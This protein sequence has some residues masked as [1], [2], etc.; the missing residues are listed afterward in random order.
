MNIQ[1]KENINNKVSNG[2]KVIDVRVVGDGSY[3]DIDVT[4]AFKIISSPAE[5]NTVYH[6]GNAEGSSYLN[7]EPKLSPKINLSLSTEGTYEFKIIGRIK[8]TTV[9]DILVPILSAAGELVNRVETGDVPTLSY[10][11]SGIININYQSESD[12]WI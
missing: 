10:V 9:G 12:G 2:D 1:I 8:T 5:S 7:Y 11:E 3:D 4:W 6:S